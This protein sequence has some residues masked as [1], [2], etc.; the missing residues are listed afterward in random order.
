LSRKQKHPLDAIFP[1]EPSGLKPL[2][3]FYKDCAVINLY[4]LRDGKVE[5]LKEP[6]RLIYQALME[7]IG[8]LAIFALLGN[9]DVT[10][11]P[12][13]ERSYTSEVRISGTWDV[14]PGA[15]LD[16]RDMVE[17]IVGKHVAARLRWTVY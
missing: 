12:F 6:P 4:T 9:G 5:P 17:S 10:D 8:G 16:V 14:V 11:L 15:P 13:L 2:L 7:L 3:E 1:K